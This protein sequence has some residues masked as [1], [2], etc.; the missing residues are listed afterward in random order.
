MLI[1][2]KL[3]IIKKNVLNSLLCESGVQ[4]YKKNIC[5]IL[6][7]TQKNRNFVQ[8]SDLLTNVDG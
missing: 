8:H 4:L 7:I 2:N 6:E 3:L 1:S 5:I